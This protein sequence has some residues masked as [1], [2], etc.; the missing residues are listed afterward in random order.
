MY[1][2]IRDSLRARRPR[3]AVSLLYEY[4]AHLLLSI[5]RRCRPEC[6]VKQDCPELTHISFS[7]HTQGSNSS[8]FAMRWTAS[9]I[10]A[11]VE[12]YL[13]SYDNR[14]R[15]SV[16]AAYRLDATVAPGARDRRVAGCA[17]IGQG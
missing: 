17:G 10:D 15:P 4:A 12:E 13:E 9:T 5:E 11:F 6:W 8:W 3:R 14:I 16:E 2:P 1:K 7:T